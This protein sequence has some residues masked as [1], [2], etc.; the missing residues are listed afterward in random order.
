MKYKYYHKLWLSFIFVKFFLKKNH[1]IS[2]IY[3][4]YISWKCSFQN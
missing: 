1:K 4:F 3:I 2:K